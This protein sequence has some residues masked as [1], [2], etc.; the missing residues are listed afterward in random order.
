MSAMDWRPLAG[1][2]PTRLQEARL[3]AHY[4]AQWLARASQAFIP[5]KPDDGHMNLG[6][7]DELGGFATHK[8]QGARIGMKL[9]PLA[10][11][12]LEGR[13]VTPGRTL[14]LDGQKESTVKT[15]FSETVNSLG[16]DA[17]ALDKKPLPYKIPPHRIA[18]GNPYNLSG[19]DDAMREL[20][21]WFSNAQKSL[22]R[23]AA[24]ARQKNLEV[25]QPR[26]WPHHFDLALQIVLEAGRGTVES[27]RSIGV[28][29][30]P[31]DIHYAEPYFYVSPWPYPPPKK[32]PPV[33]EP[34]R[35]HT[36]GFTA[37]VLPA[38][39]I[40]AAQGRQVTTEKFLIGAVG[41]AFKSLH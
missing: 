13:D 41:A 11:V 32:L 21:A 6:W 12:T 7:E 24:A 8:L 26:C 27:G 36:T 39:R 29:L 35:W 22:E 23:V 5:A 18:T 25:T 4:A 31:G 20:T 17:N 10:L 33:P 16:L 34:G 1:V 3:Q 38:Q 15:W 9:I 14:N 19:L 2:D 30:S 37:A 28:G 40:L